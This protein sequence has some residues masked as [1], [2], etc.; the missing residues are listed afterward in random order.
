MEDVR[1]LPELSPSTVEVTA[2]DRLTSVGQT[3]TQTVRLAGRSFTSEWRVEQID[4][5]RRL[6]ITGS[7]LPGTHYEMTE[8]IEA[9]GDGTRLELTMAYRLPFGPVGRLASRLGVERRAVDEAETVLAGVRDAA[10]RSHARA[11]RR[12]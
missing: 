2:P 1:L 7:V 4:P 12:T 10:E 3:F 9:D 5:G 6:V 8:S 11:A